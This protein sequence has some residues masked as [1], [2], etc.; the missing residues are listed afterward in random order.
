MI[1][2]GRAGTRKSYVINILRRMYPGKVLVTA[3]TGKAATNINGVTLHK[4]L[5]L[6]VNKVNNQLVMSETVCEWAQ[7]NFQGKQL[8][9]VDE[10]SM[11]SQEQY[12]YMDRRLRQ[13]M[14]KNKPFGRFSV[15]LSG[16]FAQL[17][18][19]CKAKIVYVDYDNESSVEKDGK[20]LYKNI[21]HAVV[22]DK[23]HRQDGES[24]F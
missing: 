17:P 7:Q 8:L 3:T 24:E 22:L 4:L 14:N 11:L 16:D 18:P 15:I 23:I 1:L 21:E 10:M 20:I 2:Y 6:P 19:V 5:F 12:G 9:V 13:I